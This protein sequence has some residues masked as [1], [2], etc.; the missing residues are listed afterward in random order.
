MRCAST[1]GRFA[2][3]RLGILVLNLRQQ[4]IDQLIGEQLRRLR[5]LALLGHSC[6]GHRT[7]FP[8]S[9]HDLDTQEI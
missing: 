2:Q 3:D 9:F 5:V 4:L 7:L 6:F 8:L 1:A